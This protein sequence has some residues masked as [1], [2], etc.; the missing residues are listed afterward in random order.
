[1][2]SSIQKGNLIRGLAQ[3]T[4]GDYRRSKRPYLIMFAFIERQTDLT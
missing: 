2:A 1:M 4:A 3:F